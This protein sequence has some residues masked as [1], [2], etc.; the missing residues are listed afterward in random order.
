MKKMTSAEY[1]EGTFL[2]AGKLVLF[3]AFY[4]LAIL[5]KRNTAFHMRYIIA[6]ALVFV[7][8]T[9]TRAV[10]YWGNVEF[11]PSFLF[12]FL[13]TDLILIGLIIFDKVRQMPCKPYVVALTGF[14]IYH[15]LWYSIFYF[16][17]ATRNL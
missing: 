9:L 5:H 10:C 11:M 15:A 1:I 13:M 16:I 7:E 12:S 2:N 17:F 3:A 8:P 4:I 14:L 6:T